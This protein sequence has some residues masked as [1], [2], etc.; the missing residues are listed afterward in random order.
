MGASEGTQL[1]IKKMFRIGSLGL[2]TRITSVVPRST[3]LE[4]GPLST[5]G[6]RRPNAIVELRGQSNGRAR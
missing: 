3:R 4:Q 6:Q 1:T 2:T 5:L